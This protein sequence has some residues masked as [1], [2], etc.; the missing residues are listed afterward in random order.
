MNANIVF[1]MTTTASIIVVFIGFDLIMKKLNGNNVSCLNKNIVAFIPVA[2]LVVINFIYLNNNIF[3]KVHYLI[4]VISIYCKYIYN[5]RLIE[6]LM[7]STTYIYS[8]KII[9]YIIYWIVFKL[10]PIYNITT[11]EIRTFIFTSATLIIFINL[12]NKI[13]KIDYHKL[14]YSFI[15]IAIT[16]NVVTVL[17]SFMIQEGTFY[18]ENNF[19][20]VTG[21]V[22]SNMLPWIMI[23][24]NIALIMIVKKLIYN[25]K[26]EAENRLIKEKMDMQYK[27]Y[28]E[29][30]EAQDK[31]KKLYHDINNHILCIDSISKNE[32]LSHLY[33][34]SIDEDLKEYRNKF[35]SENI[36]LDI[37]LNEKGNECIKRNI[38]FNVDINFEK[39]KFIEMKDVCSIFSNMIDNAIEACDKI[40]NKS[41]EKS[42]K[43]RGTIVK[44]FFVIKCENTKINKVEAVKNKI[45]TSKK[46]KFIHG[47]G[48]DSINSSIEK[49]SGDIRIENLEEKFIIKIYIPLQ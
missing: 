18:S 39:C 32:K 6:S 7:Y 36:I 48:L 24:S 5:T 23:V 3:Y 15:A 13:K 1:E 12:L 37:I 2:M 27:Y 26:I 44:N 20:N 9:R 31:I 8:Y 4:I 42:I 28:L 49:Y 19:F 41:I 43:L 30:Y 10:T 22:L 17:F 47:I 46:D 38:Q 40:E 25:T 34:K 14:Q 45:I 16:G 21:G 33:L 29:L 35:N 11:I